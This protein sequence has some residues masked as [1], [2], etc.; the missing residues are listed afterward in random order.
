MKREIIDA[1]QLE[2]TE[3]VV[4]I[5]RVTKVVKGRPLHGDVFQGELLRISVVQEAFVH[6][7]FAQAV[8]Y[9]DAGRC[10]DYRR[11]AREQEFSHCRMLS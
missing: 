10:G 1:S 11:C 8:V 7:P 4:E 3:Q 9:F 2:L 6:Q 5:K